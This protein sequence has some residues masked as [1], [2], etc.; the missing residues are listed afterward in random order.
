MACTLTGIPPR[1]GQDS[2][3]S[4]TFA[5]HGCDVSLI[6]CRGLSADTCLLDAAISHDGVS[7]QWWPATKNKHNDL[8]ASVILSLVSLSSVPLGK[9]CGTPP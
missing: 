3:H 2:W 7:W 5:V 1:D 6:T 4:K 8:K 9:G